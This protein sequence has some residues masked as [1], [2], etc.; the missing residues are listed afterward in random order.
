MTKPHDAGH[1]LSAEDASAAL[2]TRPATKPAR[3]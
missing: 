2:D 1:T 3:A